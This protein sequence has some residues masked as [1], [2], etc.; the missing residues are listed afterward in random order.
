MMAA[1][2]FGVFFIGILFGLPIA[3]AIA[4]GALFGVHAFDLPLMLVPQRMLIATDNFAMLA[5]PLFILA[6]DLMNT[7]GITQRMVNFA[8]SVVGHIRG[9][10][11]MTAIFASMI[12]AG[13][14]G[15]AV[16]DTAAIGSLLIPAMTEKKYRP[17]FAAALTS[18][19][20]TLG[21][22]IPPSILMVLYGSITNVS[23]GGLFLSGVI[24]GVLIGLLCMAVTGFFATD[25]FQPGI[26]QEPW[27]G[28]GAVLKTIRPAVPALMMPVIIIAGIIT[29]VFT[30]TEASA[31]AVLYALFV[32]MVVHREL[33]PRHLPKI[34]LDS[35]VTTCMIMLIIA[36]AS[37]FGWLLAWA[38]FPADVGN[39]LQAFTSNKYVF[40]FLLIV[41]LLL[42]GMVVEVLAICTIFG[43]LLSILGAQYGFDP[44][45]YGLVILI[46]MQ[47]GGITPPVGIVLQITCGLAKI[48]F[49]PTLKY[50]FWYIG[51]MLL[52][53]FLVIVF[54]DLALHLPNTFLSQ[55]VR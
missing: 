40:L 19:G 20:G 45:H 54:P 22:I 18:S 30:A 55:T 14:S 12:F 34:L 42:L 47:I 51:A 49:A 31:V 1:I 50:L 52:I 4:T 39:W 41:F 44:V 11:G 35:T 8:Y 26:V 43:P 37:C 29:G 9:G 48:G 33:K 32:G 5:I 38:E 28:F 6:G 25:R 16:A 2:L 7:G 17:G 21:P 15:S 23:I 24:P 13:I 10:L 53:V 27:H 3:F 46:V 36:C